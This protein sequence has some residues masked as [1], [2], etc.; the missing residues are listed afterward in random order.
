MES[1]MMQIA[2]RV[3]CSVRSAWHRLGRDESGS[4]LTLLTA[5]PVLAGAVAIGVETGE[6]YRVKRQMQV[7]A[8]AAALSASVDLLA[9]K[10]MDQATTTA[11]YEAQRNGFTDGVNSV[12]VSVSAPT[13]GTTYASTTNAVQVKIQKSMGFSIGSALLNGSLSNFS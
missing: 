8:D 9:G 1:A 7:S 4:V 6:L 10:T 11:K 13:A 5:L 12:T 3:V 2:S